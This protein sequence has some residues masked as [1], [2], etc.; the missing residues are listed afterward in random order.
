L[1]YIKKTI[2]IMAR[3]KAKRDE[4]GKDIVPVDAAIINETHQ[5][6]CPINCETGESNKNGKCKICGRELIEN[7]NY[8]KF[9]K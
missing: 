7:P 2:R 3:K 6:I 1:F 8:Q 9:E 5:Y 4:A